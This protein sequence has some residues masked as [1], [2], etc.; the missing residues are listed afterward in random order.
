MLG[1]PVQM[2]ETN[3]RVCLFQMDDLER[4]TKL[5]GVEPCLEYLIGKGVGG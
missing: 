4:D 1:V 5:E 2:D 3:G